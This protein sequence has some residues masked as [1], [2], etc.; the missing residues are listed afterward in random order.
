MTTMDLT[1]YRDLWRT[2]GVMSLMAAALTAR[3]PVMATMVPLAFLAKDA[4]GNFGWAGVVAGAYSIGTAVA[5]VVWARL[6]DRKDA[7]R[8]VI[9]TGTAWALMMAVT[10]LLPDSA[11]RLLPVAAALA[12]LFVA[13]VASTLRAAWP[14][15]VQGGRLRA[16][17]ALDASATELVFVIGP[18]FGAA[19]VSVASPRAGLLAC[20]VAAAGAIWWFG[21]KQQSGMT[22]EKRDAKR[23][24]ARELLL[25]RH[26]LPMLI[27]FACMVMGFASMS[28]GIVA[29]ADEH[30]NRLIAGVLEMVAALGSLIGGLVGGALPGRRDSYLWR[31]MLTFTVLVA[32]CFFATASVVALAVMLFASGCLI[33]PTFS[34][35]YERLGG[36]TPASARTEIFGWMLSG[37]MLGAAAGSAVAGAIVE[38]FGVRYAWALM[39]VLGVLATVAVLRV[40]PHRPVD[41][42]LASAPVAA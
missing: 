5:S 8:V 14:R 18:M 36:M 40:P 6:A 22:Q 12:G 32:G 28:L 25:H 1:A 24:T 11:Y 19:I 9:I 42:T 17:Y 7:R 39:A 30:G 21:L 23:P 2:P 34:A 20:A 27:A 38:S 4:S 13:P 35:L 37:G 10:A 33:A 29:F 3:M 26:R 16:I 15:L 31:R 41:S